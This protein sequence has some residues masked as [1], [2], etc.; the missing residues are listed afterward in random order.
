MFQGSLLVRPVRGKNQSAQ[1]VDQAPAQ[2]VRQRTDLE[3]ETGCHPGENSDPSERRD[4]TE[5]AQHYQLG[6]RVEVGVDPRCKCPDVAARS[7]DRLGDAT[8]VQVQVKDR[9]SARYRG[10]I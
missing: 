4:R 1:R 8:I 10:A 9:G 3:A 2:V 6:E 7:S 5:G